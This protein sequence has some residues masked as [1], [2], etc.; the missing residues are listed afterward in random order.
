[1]NALEREQA[2]REIRERIAELS[3]QR[4]RIVAEIAS[5]NGTIRGKRISA[6]S[7]EQTRPPV[8]C[9]IC[10]AVKFES[11]TDWTHD[12]GAWYCKL[13]AI[14]VSRKEP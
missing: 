4:D 7:T 5:L 13:C 9:C 1:M 14:H 12:L 8:F 2:E 3:Q 6:D 10:D 11:D